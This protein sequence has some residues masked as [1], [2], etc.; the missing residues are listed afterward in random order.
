[1]QA[2]MELAKG[3]AALLLN[4]VQA[5]THFKSA[6]LFGSAALLAKGAS[7]ALGGGGGGATGTASPSG[8]ALS[9]PAPQR[10]SADQE[11]M[12]FNIN[13]GGAVIYDTRR[14]AEEALADRVATVFNR[15]RRG[16]VR[17]VMMR[18]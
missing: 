18:G 13:F 16:A 8:S 15:P 9:A 7:S 14:A 17:P 5:S 10:Q 2:L 11:S 3:T 4:P 12:V 6:A 1:V